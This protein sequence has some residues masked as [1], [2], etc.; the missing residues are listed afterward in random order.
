MTPQMVYKPLNPLPDATKAIQTQKQKQNH[1]SI[2]SDV[3]DTSA[4][5]RAGEAHPANPQQPSILSSA[6]A[7]GKQFNRT[8]PILS[9]HLNTN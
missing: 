4:T 1:L 7:I 8:S 3:G 9:Y 6:G 2:M 5:Q